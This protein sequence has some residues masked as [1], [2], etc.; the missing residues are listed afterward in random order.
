MGE[1]NWSLGGRESAR[2]GGG[3][4]GEA[5]GKGEVDEKIKRCAVRN[6][7]ENRE[8]CLCCCPMFHQLR[9]R[10]R[11]RVISRGQATRS[12]NLSQRESNVG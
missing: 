5:R 3:S 9:G 12:E 7:Q 11:H 6:E 8:K 2:F 10:E 4:R 1:G